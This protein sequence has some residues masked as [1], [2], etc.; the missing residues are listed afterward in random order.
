METADT[1]EASAEYVG[2]S[3]LASEEYVIK[4]MPAILGTGD[5]IAAY[6]VA[7]FFITNT[8]IIA[9]GGT[10]A[11]TYMLLG[12]GV[13]LVPCVIATAQ[14]GTLFPHEGSLYNWTHKALGGYWS[15]FIGICL[16]LSGVLAV[17]LAANAFTTLI[18]GLNAGW[19]TQPWQQGLLMV[20]LIIATAVIATRRFRAVQNLINVIVVLTLA[21]V[22]ITGVAALVWL[23]TGHI[24][25]S[26]FRHVDDWSIAPANFW[27]F[28]PAVLSFLGIIS[29]L[30]MAGEITDSRGK[31]GRSIITRH[32]LWGTLI[33]FACYF[34]SIFALLVIRG[35]AVISAQV[36]PFEIIATVDAALGKFAG[37]LMAICV[38]GYC[39]SAA[40]FY[41]Y[42]SA[43][44]LMAAAIDGRI[45][46]SLGKLNGNRVP[47]NATI[48]QA[49]C[50]ILITIVIFIIVIFIIVPY[51]INTG[52][53]P[54]ATVSRLYIVNAATLSIIW[55][56]A[57]A[58]LFIDITFLY[59]HD[60]A[61]FRRLRILP[62]PLLWLSVVVGF[63]A[64]LAN[65]VGTLYYSWVPQIIGRN[66]WWYIVGGLTLFCLLIALGVS[67]LAN[68]Q[69]D[70]QNIR[71]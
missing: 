5:M 22:V 56:I 7:L 23:I 65:I 52:A 16:W 58:F 21:A 31:Q 63:V 43:R 36:L 54:A 20:G 46:V 60:P 39:V 18:Q 42:S 62:M 19:I 33:I 14:L 29:P 15:F 55:T 13:F 17:V 11:L 53:S 57:I 12:A 32:L 4:A 68:S 47:A 40:I 71:T 1:R 64:C 67:L 61:H 3:P 27:L 59:W 35:Q 66:S 2:V 49:I 44:I 38:L 8:A 69:A 28:G 30:N 51:A 70:W 45:P 37:T 6:I 26:S 24:A 41:T 9:T 48:F 25:A 10:A 50:A 34:V